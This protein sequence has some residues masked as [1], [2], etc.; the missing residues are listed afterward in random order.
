MPIFSSTL[1]Q[2]PIIEHAEMN[3]SIKIVGVDEKNK[4][5]KIIIKFHT[6]LCNKYTLAGFTPKLY[7]SYDCIVELV[8]SEWLEELERINKEKFIF[9]NPKHY[10]LYLD[11]IGM[12]QVVAQGFEVIEDD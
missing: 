7:G 10:A 5:R 2:D 3:M 9:W 6:V 1:E 11:E 12:F 4:L 8:D